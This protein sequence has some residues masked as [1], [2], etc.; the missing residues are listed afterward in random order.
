M[1]LE[2]CSRIVFLTEGNGKGNKNKIHVRILL[3]DPYYPRTEVLIFKSHMFFQQFND[4]RFN[5]IV[6]KSIMYN[7][8]EN[9]KEIRLIQQY[10]SFMKE[11]VFND[12]D[13]DQEI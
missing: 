1:K 8:V 5:D 10:T 3:V 6:V 12:N 13:D 7:S 2:A 9:E 11:Y 4:P